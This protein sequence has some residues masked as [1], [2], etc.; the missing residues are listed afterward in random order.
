MLRTHT[1]GELRA[2]HINAEVTLSGWVQ[3]IRDKG[4]VLWV[5][6]RDRYGL[7][8]LLLEDGQTAPDLFATARTLGREYVVQCVGTVI[9]RKAKNPNLPTGDVEIKI[10][11]LTVLNA[12][13]TPPFKIDDETDGGDDLRLKYR[14]LD[15]R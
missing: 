5:D 1:C 10:T 12:A 15:L 2:D 3:T 11:A 14:Y 8:Q 7:I 4:S 9:E 13:K 6:L